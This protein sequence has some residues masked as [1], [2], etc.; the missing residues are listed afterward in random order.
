M[1]RHLSGVLLFTLLA[2]PSTSYAYLDP[3]TGSM[4]LQ[5]IIAAIAL[6]AVTIK[7]YWH[8]FVAFFKRG[9]D[10]EPEAPPADDSQ[11]S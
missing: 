5:G 4:I 2:A 10:K 7:M 1:Y 3:G 8:K 9:N 6:S 11:D